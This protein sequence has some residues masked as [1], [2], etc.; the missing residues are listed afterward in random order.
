MGF[1][2]CHG[3]AGRCGCGVSIIFILYFSVI[4]FE[5]VTGMIVSLLFDDILELS[6]RDHVYSDSYSSNDNISNV[7]RYTVVSRYNGT[8]GR[9][10][11]I[12]L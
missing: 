1:I 11:F 7:T 3:S 8:L 6:C 9:Q 10:A 4:V 5:N 12:L 2:S